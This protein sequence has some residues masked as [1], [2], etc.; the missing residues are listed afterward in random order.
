MGGYAPPRSFFRLFPVGNTNLYTKVLS[1]ILRK[2]YD[3]II[4]G[5][6]KPPGKYR[7]YL[8]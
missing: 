8:V 7:R 4:P 6:C 1:D 3:I 5:P 2:M